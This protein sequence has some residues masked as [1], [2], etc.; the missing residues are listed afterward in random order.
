MSP[1]VSGLY[2]TC[3]VCTMVYLRQEQDENIRFLTLK[4]IIHISIYLVLG[5]LFRYLKIM[6]TYVFLFV[7]F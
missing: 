1:I 6:T 3:T 7:N 4:Y 5:S 2:N